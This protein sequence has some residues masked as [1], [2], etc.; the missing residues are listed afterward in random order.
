MTNNTEKPRT[1]LQQMIRTLELEFQRGPCEAE[2]IWRDRIL[3]AFLKH[4]PLRNPDSIYAHSDQG[5]TPCRAYTQDGDIDLLLPGIEFAHRGITVH[6]LPP[7]QIMDL[8]GSAMNGTL[9]GVDVPAY[10]AYSEDAIAKAE[11]LAEA[12]SEALLIDNAFH[13]AVSLV[14]PE[15]YQPPMLWQDDVQA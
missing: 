6:Y 14:A 2:A 13:V 11:E 3:T 8:N 5:I 15:T 12:C 7:F 1:L 10:F 4:N 9:C